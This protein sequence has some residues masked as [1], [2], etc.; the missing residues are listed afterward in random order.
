MTN[1]TA[2][3]PLRESQIWTLAFFAPAVATAI[4]IYLTKTHYDAKY[5]SSAGSALC[6]INETLSCSAATASSWSEFMGVPIAIWGA[7]ANVALLILLIAYRLVPSD[8]IQESQSERTQLRS[9]AGLIAGASIVMGTYSLVALKS[10]C[11]FCAINYLLSFASAFC[12]FRLT[13]KGSGYRL[14]P[15]KGFLAVAVGGLISG[16]MIHSQA[17]ESYVGK[18]FD[19]FVK[20]VQLEWQSNP[21][22]NLPDLGP[23]ATGASKQEARMVI[24]EFADFRCIHCKNA[25]EPIKKFIQSKA[26]VRLEFYAWPLDG[27]CN[28]VIPQKSGASCLLARVAWCA[29]KKAQKGSI[30][31]EEIFRRFEKWTSVGAI[32]SAI[33]ELSQS[34]GMESSTL[35]GCSKSE[36]AKI[37][38]RSHADLGIQLDIKG[39]P[40]IYVNGKLLPGGAQ[41]EILNAIY[42]RIAR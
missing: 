39:T 9:L 35:E 40:A 2:N 7:L 30:A 11:P 19:Q 14:M 20:T 34:I 6:D 8:H 5:T 15:T 41:R 4:H 16:F 10:L 22:V 37:A 38:V 18:G 21:T 17:K 32:E 3:A 31:H 23:I 25:V 27:E 29:E 42:E 26:D 13:A 12:V 36:E 1:Q 24:T 33:P 28:S